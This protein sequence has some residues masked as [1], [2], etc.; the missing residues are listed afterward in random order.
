MTR[1]EREYHIGHYLELEKECSPDLE[2][3][4]A[5]EVKKARICC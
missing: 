5:E 4:T 3:M 1:R 2:A